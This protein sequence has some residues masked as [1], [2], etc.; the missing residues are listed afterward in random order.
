M[1]LVKVVLVLLQPDAP[2]EPHLILVHRKPP[3]A[4]I[5]H[6]L[7]KGAHDCVT[8]ALMKKALA[9]LLTERPRRIV[10]DVE[11]ETDRVEEIRL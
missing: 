5:E 6:E 9:L 4:V 8:G 7:D 10:Q 2:P 3:I 11:D 1:L